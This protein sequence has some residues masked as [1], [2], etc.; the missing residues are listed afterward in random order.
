MIVKKLFCILRMF[1]GK[2]LKCQTY[3]GMPISF[4]CLY[5][6]VIMT[7]CKI[8]HLSSEGPDRKYGE[9]NLNAVC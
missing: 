6:N 7:R 8:E 3:E 5:T 2:I 1:S 9:A 4:L